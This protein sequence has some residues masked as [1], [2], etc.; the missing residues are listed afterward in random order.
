MDPNDRPTAEEA[1]KAKFLT[2]RLH[3]VFSVNTMKGVQES[4]VSYVQCNK[5]KQLALMVIAYKSSM[6]E[7]TKLRQV[8]SKYD[9]NKDGMISLT[10]F[11]SA[12]SGSNFTDDDIDHMFKNLVSSMLYRVLM[13][14]LPLSNL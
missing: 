4:L 8:F 11:K 3:H 5:L 1:L 6:D 14:F 13:H 2:K 12:L 9:K 7:V 10:E